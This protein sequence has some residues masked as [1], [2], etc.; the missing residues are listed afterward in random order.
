MASEVEAKLSSIE[1]RKGEWEKF[2]D[3]KEWREVTR[4][5]QEHADALLNK[6][7]HMEVKDI[8]SIIELLDARARLKGVLAQGLVAQDILREYDDEANIVSKQGEV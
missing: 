7:C 3:S 6:V 1:Y 5:G 2:F 8:N 4:R